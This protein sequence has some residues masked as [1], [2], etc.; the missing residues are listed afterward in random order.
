MSRSNVR[1]LAVSP[2]CV[3]AVNR[4]IYRFLASEHGFT[5]HLVLPS[6]TTVGSGWKSCEKPRDE[7]I[8]TTLLD[9]VGVHPNLQRL[10]GL[11]QL[12]AS[13]GPTHVLIDNNPGTMMVRQVVRCVSRLGSAR[14]K[15]WVQTPENQMPDALR[16]LRLGVRQLKPQLIGGPLVAWWLRKTVRPGVDR[17]FT[18]SSDGTRV[19]EAL[20]FRGVT[21]TPLGFDRRL[22]HPQTPDVIAS[23]RA[24]LGLTLPTIAYFGRLVHEKGLH[25]LLPALASVKDLQWQFL[26]DR[27]SAYQTS[28]ASSVKNQLESLG[29]TERVVFFD[30]THSEMPNYVNAADFIVLPSVSTLKWKEQYGRV[31]PEGMACGKIVIGSCSGAIPEIIGDAGY[32]FPERDSVALGKLLRTLLKQEQ[33]SLGSMRDAAF[34]RSHDYYSVDRQAS[35]MAELA[36]ADCP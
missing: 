3:T 28:Y 10:L 21:Q 30:A 24:R 27:F 32:T 16:D 36:E 8:E 15:V 26:I 7:P 33:P 13:W 11:E 14:P 22:F 2:P 29:L 20:G 18:A 5:I 25:I 19:M 9:V 12:I 35:I 23:T 6:R 4:A 1:M 34:R 31:V 17:V